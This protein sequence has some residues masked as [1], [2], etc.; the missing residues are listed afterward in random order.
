MSDREKVHSVPRFFAFAVAL[1][2][3]EERFDR[4]RQVSNISLRRSFPVSRNRYLTA[5]A[6]R[7]VVRRN[8]K[9]D[10]FRG[11]GNWATARS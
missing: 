8:E 3:T 9:K 6:T 11:G 1:R 5:D 7:C 2:R 4:E 10:V